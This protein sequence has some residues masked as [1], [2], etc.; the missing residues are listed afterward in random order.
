MGSSPTLFFTCTIEHFYDV[1]KADTG[2]KNMFSVCKAKGK[3]RIVH[4]F[5]PATDCYG[6][7]IHTLLFA[8]FLF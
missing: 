5:S 8:V 3:V 4:T 2:E 1:H 7:T 6:Y